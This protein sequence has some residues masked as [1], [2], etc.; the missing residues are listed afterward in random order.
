MAGKAAGE[1]SAARSDLSEPRKSLSAGMGPRHTAPFLRRRLPYP[2][3][4]GLIFAE[5]AQIINLLMPNRIDFFAV[6]LYN[7][8]IN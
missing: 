3:V 6:L 8:I 4:D 2:V 7:G 1:L 5:T